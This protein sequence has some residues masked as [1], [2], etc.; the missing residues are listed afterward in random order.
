MYGINEIIFYGTQ[1][2]CRIAEICEKEAGGE[3]VLYYVL[4]PVFFGATSVFVPV[5][6]PELT[7]RMRPL[8]SAE[9][10]QG[11]VDGIETLGTVW[12]DDPN[13]RRER[14]KQILLCGR[15]E[16]LCAL[17]KTLW[18]HRIRQRGRGKKLHMTD[19]RYLKEAEKIFYSELGYVLGLEPEQLARGVEERLSRCV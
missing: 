19:E 5:G 11:L 4:Q 6:S 15:S 12:I 18:L 14:F 8:L 7:G 16:E 10:A 17:I 3:N 13:L 2:V 9:K 1:G